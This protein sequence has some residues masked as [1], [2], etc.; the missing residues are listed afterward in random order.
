MAIGCNVSE[1]KYKNV[2]E[3]FTP[4]QLERYGKIV[5]VFI[6]DILFNR[7]GNNIYS[8]EDLNN[9]KLIKKIY[10]NIYIYINNI[11]GAAEGN[12][13]DDLNLPTFFNSE[14]SSNLKKS[15][16]KD[17][18]NL[19]DNFEAFK[20]FNIENGGIFKVKDL[21]ELQNENEQDLGEDSDPNNDEELSETKQELWDK[22]PNERDAFLNSSN[23][24]K[25]LFKLLYETI[26][27]KRTK[28]Y[29]LKLDSDGLPVNLSD[30]DAYNLY[31]KYFNNIKSEEEFLNKIF[32]PTTEQI[33]PYVIQIRNYLRLR[34]P[35]Q[36]DKDRQLFIQLR[37][38][39]AKPEIRSEILVTNSNVQG[40]TYDYMSNPITGNRRKIMAV[41]DNNFN[42]KDSKNKNS[43]GK[44]YLVKEDVNK[45]IS[46]VDNAYSILSN[47][48]INLSRS[49]I[50]TLPNKKDIDSQVKRIAENIQ[51]K[52]FLI[53]DTYKN[54]DDSIKRQLIIEPIKDLRENFYNNPIIK[55]NKTLFK[56]ISN[57]LSRDINTL[58]DI[59]SEISS[60]SPSQSSKNAA[61]EM[62]YNISNETNITFGI[63]A[64]N[65]SNKISDLLNNPVAHGLNYNPY[66]R[67]SAYR[68]F[69][70]DSNGNRKSSNQL[71]LTYISGYESNIDGS[72]KKLIRKLNYVEKLIFD[73]KSM[74]GFGKTDVMRLSTSN[75][76]PSIAMKTKGFLGLFSRENQ[77]FFNFED[78]QNGVFESVSVQNQFLGYLNSEIEKI[79]SYSKKKKENPLLSETYGEFLLFEKLDKKLKDKLLSFDRDITREDSVF[80]D[81]K[82]SYQKILEEK[83]NSFKKFFYKENIEFKEM[84][85]S[86]LPKIFNPYGEEGTSKLDPKKANTILNYFVINNIVQNMEFGIYF[87][88]DP[89]NY[90]KKE[91]DITTSDLFKR[92][93]ALSSTAEAFPDISNTS[94]TLIDNSIYFKNRSLESRRSKDKNKIFTKRDPKFIRSFM[95]N[96]P[97]YDGSFKEYSS[98]KGKA[99]TADGSGWISMDFL[100]ELSIRQGWRNGYTDEVFYYESL[101]YKREFTSTPLN[102]LELMQIA[103]FEKKQM[104][105]PELYAIPVMKGG[106][107]GNIV[108]QTIDGK[109]NDKF[110]L[111][112]LLPS[113]VVSSSNKTLKKLM[114]DMIDNQIDYVKPPSSNKGF[115]SKIINLSEVSSET[116]DILFKE[117]F[118]LQLAYSNESS[119]DTA[120]PT[121]LLKLIYSNQFDKGVAKSEKIKDLYNDYINILGLIKR[122]N[123]NRLFEELGINFKENGEYLIDSEKFVKSIYKQAIN[124]N[125]DSNILNI[126]KY[127]PETKTFNKNPEH[128]GYGN[129]IEKL[130]S[131][132]I[133][134][135]LRRFKVNG[136]DFVVISNAYSDK[137]N[138]YTNEKNKITSSE[139]R[140]TFTKEYTKL[141][142]K[143]HPDGKPIGNLYRLN[144]LLKD[145]DWRKENKKS[146][147][148][149]VDRVPTQ[150][151]N[152]MDFL[153]IVEFLSPSMGN[154]IQLPVEI[155]IKAGLDFDYD[156][157]KVLL[158]LFDD[159]GE[160][161]EFQ[162]TREEIER[163]L[164]KAIQERDKKL[165]ENDIDFTELYKTFSESLK[166][167]RENIDW[168]K[169][170][171]SKLKE[172]IQLLKLKIES[173]ANEMHFL[174]NEINSIT[175]L[176]GTSELESSNKLFDTIFGELNTIELS[177]ESLENEYFTEQSEQVQRLRDL[178]SLQD[179]RVSLILKIQTHYKKYKDF[180]Q[181]VKDK[182]DE[183]I[184]RIR[185]YHDEVERLRSAKYN[186]FNSL[187]NQIINNYYNS[188]SL[189]DRF[190]NL[191][192]PNSSDKIKKI[193][194]NI[195]KL[196]E[197]SKKLPSKDLIFDYLSQL[198]VF[199][200]YNTS[201]NMLSPYAKINTVEKVLNNQNILLNKYTIDKS[202]SIDRRTKKRKLGKRI[203]L[204]HLILSPEEEYL[205]TQN[206][207]YSISSMYGVDG[208]EIQEFNSQSIN[209][210]VDAT[211]DPFFI[212]LGI[213]YANVGVDILFSSLFKYPKERVA[214]F[215]AHPV[216]KLYSKIKNKGSE[217]DAIGEIA[218][219]WNL[220]KIITLDKVEYTIE[221]FNSIKSS[222]KSNVSEFKYSPKTQTYK[223]ENIEIFVKFD[224]ITDIYSNNG[225]RDFLLLLNQ[226]IVLKSPSISNIY[227]GRTHISTYVN[228]LTRPGTDIWEKLANPKND[229]FS[230]KESDFSKEELIR[231]ELMTFANFF[232]SIKLNKAFRQLSSYLSFD[233]NKVDGT[234]GLLRRRELRN[235]IL[236]SQMI[237]EEDLIKL[238]E[239]SIVSA[240]KHDDSIE[241]SFK[242]VNPTTTNF[243]QSLYSLYEEYNNTFQDKNQSLIRNLPIRIKN[244]FLFSI[245]ANFGE[246]VKNGT[247]C[248]T[249]TEEPDIIDRLRTARLNPDF[250]SIFKKHTILNDLVGHF[251]YIN[252]ENKFSNI[253][254]LK[255]TTLSK[256]ERESYIER[257]TKLFKEN[258]FSKDSKVNQAFKRLVR[259]LGDVAIAQSGFQE[260]FLS[261][262]EFIPVDFYYEDF[263]KAYEEFKKLTPSQ[264]YYYIEDFKLKFKDNNR[265]YFP[266]EKKNMLGKIWKDSKNRLRN[267]I[268][269]YNI[270]L[271]EENTI[272]PTSNISIIEKFD[273]AAKLPT[274]KQNL[275]DGQAGRM[276]LPQFKGKSTMDL[277]LSGDRTRTTRSNTE[278]GRMIRD[279]NPKDGDIFN[280]KGMII[281]QSDNAGNYTFTEI[282]GVYQFT[283][284]YQNETW[285]KEGWRKEVTDKLIGQYPIAIEFRVVKRPSELMT[286]S[287]DTGKEEVKIVSNI[288][289]NS[290]IEE[291]NLQPRFFTI[292]QFKIT[293]NA[294]GS[295]FFDNGNEVTDQIIKNKVI[296]KK[297]LQDGTLRK[298]E[299]NGSIYFITSDNKIMG[300][301]KTNLG[302]ETIKD[303]NIIEKVLAKAVPYKSQNCE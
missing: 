290:N 133:D 255:S 80:N 238:E 82:I 123:V 195:E 267:I 151:L 106:Y 172:Q 148:I 211:K 114:N 205:N 4:Y 73:F 229:A 150:E 159:N 16:I 93:S 124:R 102:N 282:T 72:K 220:H 25:I 180:A 96:E 110:S 146:L 125:L 118:K 113:F 84:L 223:G 200:I 239:K 297:E 177:K 270:E 6:S 131:G 169:V 44:R 10:S 183:L 204:N 224:P 137:L 33:I 210:T 48:G 19:K 39:S 51:D 87:V 286:I 126:I 186:Y 66:F 152:S 241:E 12:K 153:D 154:V 158:P 231:L 103:D 35:E 271:V 175:K 138:F 116:P 193:S 83:V 285:H 168:E 236:K 196:T 216:N 47:I 214:Q 75:S 217:R 163:N 62:I 142:N 14:F 178:Q 2:N 182:E 99:K 280:L 202:S 279:Y 185:P 189:S 233:T 7:G 119:I 42:L 292:N 90:E 21:R 129:E 296:I 281:R 15:V 262:R 243:L 254:L 77:T 38:L 268:K 105:N 257:F 95:I 5:N 278:V 127:N 144:V 43:F 261:Y 41:W 132:L 108:N 287:E 161:V 273:L 208:S 174:L 197:D 141:L 100:Y 203:G 227:I 70:F 228:D 209:A 190:D 31:I 157:E 302:K 165:E 218:N 65:K 112:P 283:Q 293:L 160:Y 130:L 92:L 225:L 275:K 263:E 201:K 45:D 299:W 284:E 266:K 26:Y 212:N 258:N 166:E 145:K 58:L 253:R 162:G 215:L 274:I 76:Y 198:T 187:S 226:G 222:L 276:M 136:G 179:E 36:S 300:S 34:N 176:E 134:R 237:S 191:I 207:K 81:F 265:E 79:K 56:K 188:L 219:R 173:S 20:Y 23:N 140:I 234:F 11:I 9:P 170:D 199:D 242:T 3:A 18:K 301:G 246:K 260:S 22:S 122:E 230:E 245:I 295:M 120:I 50:N 86:N 49:V 8:I 61:G 252:S 94:N 232:S 135:T 269:N 55:N 69:L 78:F 17:L 184:K 171:L 13:V 277:I 164:E 298:S 107:F 115:K 303:K 156:K 149:I 97:L 128:F 89:S 68:K 221:E 248:I 147:Q 104:T 117:L 181:D 259:D 249:T 143:I 109:E 121:Q 46:R 101:I 29:K 30:K 64:L 54:V 247:K 291:K 194:E 1:I 53:F 24:I 60:I 206:Y 32:D 28:S 37:N 27:D 192:R 264:L 244:D 167:L 256:L 250:E 40:D 155:V 85:P 235:D 272:I 251:T 71:Q 98:E 288:Q 289:K 240:F 59:E 111:V 74:I 139:C 52:L 213:N 67:N 57:T 88:G 294:D 91:G 63:N